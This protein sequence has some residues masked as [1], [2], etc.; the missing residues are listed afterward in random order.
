MYQVVS[1]SDTQK[2]GSEA[3]YLRNRYGFTNVAENGLGVFFLQCRIIIHEGSTSSQNNTTFF[4]ESSK[5]CASCKS[6]EMTQFQPETGTCI[7]LFS[8]CH[9]IL[10]VK[11]RKKGERGEDIISLTSFLLTG[12]PVSLSLHFVKRIAIRLLTYIC[13][14]CKCWISQGL[15]YLNKYSFSTAGIY[16]SEKFC[17]F[18]E[19]ISR[20]NQ[21]CFMYFSTFCTE[22]TFILCCILICK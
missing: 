8:A 2:F 10:D 1:C 4:P 15:F 6:W 14:K 7:P 13:Q 11:R 17:M 22:I 19:Y 18:A 9:H 20:E 5:Q 3:A 16:R 21:P 12:I